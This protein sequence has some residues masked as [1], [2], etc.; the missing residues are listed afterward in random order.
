MPLKDLVNSFNG[1]SIPNDIIRIANG[2][3]CRD[4]LTVGLLVDELKIQNNTDIKTLGN[5]VPD[6]W[7][8]VQE[9]EVKLLRLQIFNNW[10]PFM[11]K[12]PENNVWI[13]AEYTCMEND[14]LWSMD[15]EEL[16]DFVASELVKLEGLINHMF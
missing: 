14:E 7:I 2:L 6:N 12:N 13:G 10:S 9:E 15:D 3:P 16:I 11:L 4:F 5:I 8:Y 1:E